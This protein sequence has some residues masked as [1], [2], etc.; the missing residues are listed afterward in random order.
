MKTL[1]VGGTSTLGLALKP[2]LAE[3][4]EVA[5]AGRKDCDF[6]LDLGDPVERI[7]MPP[8]VDTVVHA[9]ANFGGLDISEILAAENINVLGTLKLCHAAAEG[10]VKHFV[11]ISSIFSC[12]KAESALFSVYALS[13]KHAEEAA[14]FYCNRHSL[15]LTI[16]RPSQ[17]YGN[18]DSYRT[19]QPFFYSII[20]K[21]S[22]GEDI[23]L[24]GANDARRNY[25]HIDD[26][27]KVIACVV[28]E[29]IEGVYA[30]MHPQ[31]I[32]F[33]QIARAAFNAFNSHAQIRF[34][35]DQEDIPDNVF[36]QDDSLYQKIGFYPQI[37]IEEGMRQIA[38]HRIEQT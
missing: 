23:T 17:I 15:A 35:K 38:Q 31:D 1:I 9:G 18:D 37:S 16:L 24:Y 27:V 26:L 36:K 7:S 21:A 34:L 19:H 28:K 6:V 25:I 22:R 11:F 4:S 10:G 30:C 5:T 3:F 2:A 32:S 29:R 8:N 33:T 13:K 12:M 20:D 14:R